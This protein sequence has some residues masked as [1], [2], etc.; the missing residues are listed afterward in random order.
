MFADHTC[1]WYYAFQNVSGALNYIDPLT[2]INS[3]M[4]DLTIAYPHEP[5]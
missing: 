4:C 2:F 3:E 1:T 5:S